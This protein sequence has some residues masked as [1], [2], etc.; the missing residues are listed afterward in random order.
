MTEKLTIYDPAEDLVS[1]EAIENSW[2]KRSRRT[3]PV[4]SRT[5]WASPCAQA[6]PKNINNPAESKAIPQCHHQNPELSHQ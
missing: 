1:D 3:M 2:P 5:R 6:T 4:T